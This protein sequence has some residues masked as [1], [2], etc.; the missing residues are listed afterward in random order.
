MSSPLSIRFESDL[1]E[2]LRA[3]AAAVPGSTVSGLAQR[4]V[5]E[6]LRADEHPGIV[7]RD[8]PAGRRAGLAC[9]PDIWEVIK[10]LREVDERGPAAIEA[11]A[12]MMNLLE[13]RVHAAIR[14]Y[15]AYPEEIDREITQADTESR[16]AEAAW[17]AAQRLLS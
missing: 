7:F 17:E 12:E 9:G 11:T 4:F 1:L 15:M 13:S 8:G 16:E 3:K 14:Y 2:R 5:D 6:G 10:F